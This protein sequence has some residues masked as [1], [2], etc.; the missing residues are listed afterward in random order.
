MWR[1]MPMTSFAVPTC[2]QWGNAT[3]N[4]KCALFDNAYFQSFRSFEW[5]K[6]R[7]SRRGHFLSTFA[8][9][10]VERTYLVRLSV[11]FYSIVFLHFDWE[12][13]F[14]PISIVLRVAEHFSLGSLSI[15]HVFRGPH[16]AR[17]ILLPTF[18]RTEI[19]S[20]PTFDRAYV[21][22]AHE[23]FVSKFQPSV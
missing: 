11:R 17:D 5:H 15:I 13:H 3:T 18:S 1:H 14:R 22:R 12:I 16:R 19:Q 4:T 10:F 2:Y 23:A 20:V 21:L 9:I 6:I 8:Y 7:L